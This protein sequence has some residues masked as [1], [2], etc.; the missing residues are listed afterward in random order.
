[1]WIAAILVKQLPGK[2]T[3]GEFLPFDRDGE[4]TAAREKHPVVYLNEE[5]RGTSYAVA[6]NCPFS[7]CLTHTFYK[8]TFS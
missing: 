3:V 2:G 6:G 1:M 7:M 8:R 5:L 4:A